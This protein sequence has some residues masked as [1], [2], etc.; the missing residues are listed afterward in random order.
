MKDFPLNELISATELNKITAAI[1][2][3]LSHLKKIKGS[4]YPLVRTLKLIEAISKDLTNQLLKVLSTQRLMAIS[5]DD[6]E[7][8]MKSCLSVFT[9][10]DDEYEKLQAMLRDY[11]KRKRDE[12]KMV[13]LI[14]TNI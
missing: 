3:I 5:F 2:S 8:T 1:V 14:E 6:F 10:W 13:R 9:A 4:K 12:F 11:A 7:K